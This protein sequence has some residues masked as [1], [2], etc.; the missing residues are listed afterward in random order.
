MKHINK[1]IGFILAP[2]PKECVEFIKTQN[3]I[4]SSKSKYLI[5]NLSQ[6]KFYLKNGIEVIILKYNLNNKQLNN[7]LK[8]LDGIFIDG[9]F[10]GDN[11]YKE[12][13][14][15]HIEHFNFL[16]T[17]YE[18]VLNINKNIRPFFLGGQCYSQELIAKILENQSYSDNKLVKKVVSDNVNIFKKST[19]FY[20]RNYYIENK[21]SF[22]LNMGV[23]LQDFKKTKNLQK[24]FKVIS[25]YNLYN[26][27]ILD[28]IKHKKYPIFFSKSACYRNNYNII[29]EMFEVIE[30]SN[31][32]RRHFMN[33][34]VVIPNLNYEKI[35]IDKKIL[36]NFNWPF[37]GD[38][39]SINILKL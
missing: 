18:K 13:D 29:K 26:K 24:K 10:A 23:F 8:T 30:I 16:K 39:N 22:N 6:E 33:K 17:V 5:M 9:N 25:V 20:D 31:Y 14:S 2:F 15:Q 36:N 1:R 32:Y 3:I 21:S 37:P 12:K 7:I 27:E 19:S 35:F 34:K 38:V 28:I 11:W 4:D